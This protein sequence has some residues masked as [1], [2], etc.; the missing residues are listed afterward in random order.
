[1]MAK[2]KMSR[3]FEGG[4]HEIVCHDCTHRLQGWCGNSC[5]DCIATVAGSLHVKGKPVTKADAIAILRR[6]HDDD[7][8]SVKTRDDIAAFLLDVGE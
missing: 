5:G 1:M 6:I 2:L 4:G 3:L 8:L 7:E